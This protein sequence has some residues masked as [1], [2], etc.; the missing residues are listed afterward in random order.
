MANSESLAAKKSPEDTGRALVKCR[1][2]VA[3]LV[4]GLEELVGENGMSKKV[5]QA[6]K[7]VGMVDACLCKLSVDRLKPG[8]LKKSTKVCKK[9]SN[10]LEEERPVTRLSE[11]LRQ[12]G[13]CVSGLFRL[14]HHSGS[15]DV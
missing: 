13:H 1:G 4:T 8:A 3:Q 2:T 7:E 12:M 14:Q 5:K 15:C 11:R 10:L 6:L 9:H